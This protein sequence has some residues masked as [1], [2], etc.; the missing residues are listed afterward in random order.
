MFGSV[1]PDGSKPVRFRLRRKDDQ[2]SGVRGPQPAIK[3][4]ERIRL[5]LF[6]CGTMVFF[7]VLATILQRGR[8]ATPSGP[9]GLGEQLDD[10]VIE[11]RPLPDLEA[12]AALPDYD[13]L[14][15]LAS[16]VAKHLDDHRDLYL[17]FTSFSP[18]SFA[19]AQAQ[20]LRDREQRPSY[21][22]FDVQSILRDTVPLGAPLLVTGGLVDLR[23]ETIVGSGGDGRPDEEWWRMTVLLHNLH[24]QSWYL[25]VVAPSWAMPEDLATG[26]TL[27]FAGRYLGVVD[28]PAV[29]DQM[30]PI[31]TMAAGV[32]RVADQSEQEVIG[33]L[34]LGREAAAGGRWRSDPQ[35]FDLID[36]SRFV[37][38][39]RPYYYLLGKVRNEA[40]VERDPYRDAEDGIQRALDLHL[41]PEDFRGQ[42]FSIEGRVWD[43]REDYEVARD[44]PFNV[45][46]VYRIRLWKRVF[47][48]DHPVQ[49]GDEIEISRSGWLHLFELAVIDQ[50]G[51]KP[52]D[53]PQPGQMVRA[54]GR[55]L[56]VHGYPIAPN[57]LRDHYSGI[58][59]QSNEAYAKLF[60]VPSFEI[61]PDPVP[62]D[63]TYLTIIFLGIAISFGVWMA[64]LIRGETMTHHA[65]MG[66]V[67]RLRATRRKLHKQAAQNGQS[68]A[69]DDGHDPVVAADADAADESDPDAVR[70]SDEDG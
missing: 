22:G 1:P 65:V 9:A 6:C 19:W 49:R 14:A 15:A 39:L 43:V 70:N 13:T 2:P 41:Q 69:S 45:R 42:A 18:S 31:P 51:L 56:K 27:R 29:D 53:L 62:I 46:R 34:G 54:R 63:W 67:E 16:R 28:M 50:G 38:E 52:E 32:V 26:D 57:P 3:R 66:P 35:V 58:S 20:L 5:L 55:F 8:E 44:Q 68:A 25:H 59:R 17:H 24:E 12:V 23:S 64:V 7:V 48:V 60:V 47:G 30:V 36:D 37:L 10:V 11:D 33:L 4:R 61:L 40:S 21:Q